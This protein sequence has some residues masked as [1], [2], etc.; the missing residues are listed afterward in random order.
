[1]SCEI[2]LIAEIGQNSGVR[3]TKTGW[4][5]PGERSFYWLG[6]FDRSEAHDFDKI[7][8]RRIGASFKA[9]EPVAYLLLFELFSWAVLCLNSVEALVVSSAP[10][11]HS[12]KMNNTNNFVCLLIG[13]TA[14]LI[15]EPHFFLASPLALID[16]ACP[17]T[18]LYH[19]HL[20]HVIHGKLYFIIQMSIYE[21]CELVK[22]L[23]TSVDIEHTAI[24]SIGYISNGPILCW[25]KDILK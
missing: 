3:R 21:C 1:M 18:R 13:W 9:P 15:D 19:I 7:Y 16:S 20:Q 2:W 5:Q 24:L 22:S 4:L 25:F 12:Q 23:Y 17:R 14:S 8:G 10:L 6:F 11:T